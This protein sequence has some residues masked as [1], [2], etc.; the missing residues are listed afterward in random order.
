[1]R[2][3]ISGPMTG[4][5][6]FNYPAFHAVAAELRAVGHHV[7]NPAE[8]HEPECKSW[9]G[10]MRLALAQLVF[11]E[12]IYMLRGWERSKGARIEFDLAKALN[13][14]LMFE[15]AAEPDHSRE[16]FASRYSADPDDPACRA[17]FAIYCAGWADADRTARAQAPAAVEPVGHVSSIESN[18]PLMCGLDERDRV[19]LIPLYA[20]P[21]T[22]AEPAPT[23]DELRQLSRNCQAMPGGLGMWYLNYGRAVLGRWGVVQ[24]APEDALD[25]VLT[26][27]IGCLDAANAEGLDDA[28]VNN[29]DARLT[30]LVQ[31]RLLPAFYAAI[32][33]QAQKGGAA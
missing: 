30:D 4:R 8:N 10:Y 19:G 26:E 22:N 20:A 33:A 13:I 31:R 3:Y 23:D 24:A 12:A 7:E 14:E 25:A 16:G 11:C 27:I 29:T 9:S 6:E 32:A 17:D 2:I 21:T 5:P 18:S 1:M 28:L 15:G